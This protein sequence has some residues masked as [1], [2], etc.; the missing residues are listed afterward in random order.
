MAVAA[1]LTMEHVVS[2]S[3]YDAASGAAY[4][5]KAPQYVVFYSSELRQRVVL[6][7]PAGDGARFWGSVQAPANVRVETLKGRPYF[8]AAVYWAPPLFVRLVADSAPER[9]SP[10]NADLVGRF[11]PAVGDAESVMV[12]EGDPMKGPQSVIASQRAGSDT[13]VV[14]RIHGDGLAI[15]AR[16]GVATRIAVPAKRLN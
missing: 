12:F 4:T 9:L 11:Y 14:R 3:T 10:A 15:L 16:I 7:G 6:K 5:V 13:T 8:S 2:T 1:C